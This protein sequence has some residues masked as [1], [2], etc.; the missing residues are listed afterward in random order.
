MATAQILLLWPWRFRWS[1]S[2]KALTPAS[3]EKDLGDDLCFCPACV[4]QVSGYCLSV[5]QRLSVEALGR[6]WESLPWFHLIQ[7]VLVENLLANLPSL[8][9]I[10]LVVSLGRKLSVS[11]RGGTLDFGFHYSQW[12]FLLSM[13]LSFGSTRESPNFQIMR[14][15]LSFQFLDQD[16]CCLLLKDLGNNSSL[17]L[18]WCAVDCHRI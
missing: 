13:A 10:M 17:A 9:W 16:P 5:A 8:L 6:H 7:H 4:P 1:R 11:I 15:I 18:S 3:V 12:V 2:A 14:S